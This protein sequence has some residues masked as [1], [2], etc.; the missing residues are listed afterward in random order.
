MTAANDWDFFTKGVTPHR[1]VQLIHFG[2]YLH[3][4]T[5]CQVLKAVV[6]VGLMRSEVHAR[7]QALD[8]TY[9]WP[10]ASERTAA[11]QLV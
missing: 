6:P 9:Q 2:M 5:V 10:Q 8:V 11:D 3:N 4:V 1:C 7:S